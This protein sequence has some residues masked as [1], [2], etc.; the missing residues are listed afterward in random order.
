M[1]GSHCGR[2]AEPGTPPPEAAA[3]NAAV[4]QSLGSPP[5]KMGHT[6]ASGGGVWTPEA[7]EE[8]GPS[9]STPVASSAASPPADSDTASTRVAAADS[10][11]AAASTPEEAPESWEGR[12][13]PVSLGERE[14]EG[15]S[16]GRL[17][18]GSS[19]ASSPQGAR[20][21]SESPCSSSAVES[22]EHGLLESGGGVVCRILYRGRSLPWGPCTSLCRSPST[23]WQEAW[24]ADAREK[25]L[26]EI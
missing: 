25:K 5:G 26:P 12:L 6:F 1:R 21:P 13:P 2:E 8:A 11:R 10:S 16:K 4:C 20:T 15:A 18:L 23:G 3:A 7:P 14:G 19:D 22:G 9:A 17:L 24:S